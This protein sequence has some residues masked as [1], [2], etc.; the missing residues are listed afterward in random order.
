ML[1]W[2]AWHRRRR[3]LQAGS[4]LN[5]RGTE[6]DAVSVAC[7]IRNGQVNHNKKAECR[8]SSVGEGIQCKSCFCI[9][10]TR[11]PLPGPHL[12]DD[13][14]SSLLFSHPFLSGMGWGMLGWRAASGA[15]ALSGWLCWVFLGFP[16]RNSTSHLSSSPCSDKQTIRGISARSKGTVRKGEGGL[17]LAAAW[18]LRW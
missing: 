12:A 11:F 4:Q 5:T 13:V 6:C 18:G 8:H 3:K 16:K 9:F 1:T 15:L 17:N 14:W 2:P 7:G 10:A